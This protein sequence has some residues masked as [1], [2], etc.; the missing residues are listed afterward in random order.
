[1]E[2]MRRVAAQGAT[3]LLVSHSPSQ[4]TDLCTRGM[5]MSNGELLFDGTLEEASCLYANLSS[6]LNADDC[7]AS[8]ALIESSRP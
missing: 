2:R 6:P 1:M 4:L 3:I 8:A 5:F 7:A